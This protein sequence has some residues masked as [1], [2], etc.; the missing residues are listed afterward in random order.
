[1]N[2]FEKAIAAVSP[3]TALKRANARNRLNIINS[4]YSNYGASHSKNSLLGW[5]C[6]GGSAKEDIQENLS[7]LR[8]RSRDLYM[9]V[10]IA[11]GAVKTM[12]TN[13]VGSGLVLKSQIDYEFLK[14]S[15][16]QAQITESDIER[17]FALWAESEACDIERFDNFCDLQQLAFLNWLM[18][19]DVIVLLPTTKRVNSPYDLRICL[20]ESDRLCTPDDTD[21]KNIIGGVE[22]NAH[23]EVVAYHILNHHPLSAELTTGQAWKRIEAFGKTSGRRNVLHVMSRER[24]GQRR[25]VP[26]LAPIIEPIKQL[27]RYTQA[28]IDAAVTSGMFA[29]LI[30]TSENSGDGPAIGEIVPE[31]ERVTSKETE[32][33]IGSGSIVELAPGEKPHTVSPGRPNA[34]FDGFVTAVT[35]HIGSA[36]EIPYEVLIKHYTASFSASR[37]AM[38]EFWKTVKMYR[39]WLINDFCQPIFEEWLAE[40]VAKGRV[41]APGFF[42]NWLIEFFG[43]LYCN[44][45]V[46]ASC[47]TRDKLNP[48]SETFSSIHL[49]ILTVRF[50]ARPS[51]GSAQTKLTNSAFSDSTSFIFEGF[52]TGC[53]LLLRYSIH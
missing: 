40:A 46:K 51:L 24:I 26:F 52:G 13:V 12:R 25:G 50:M 35:R 53:C 31:H 42:Q 14:L 15:E 33:E 21:N 9:G 39:A 43:T 17:E 44:L 1:M 18:S 20:I 27:G 8:Q 7:T 37:G 41:K 22:T 11:T 49:G 16:E 34:N 48:V 23:G 47:K 6:N 38:L 19:G 4:G 10:P 3:K 45:C 32:L 29:V 5:F 36:L 2:I 30:E 28:E